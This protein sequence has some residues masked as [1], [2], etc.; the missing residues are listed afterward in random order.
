ME[1][2]K[3][4]QGIKDIQ[5]NIEFKNGF[6]KSK[7][8]NYSQV[9]KDK[10]L[11][12]K[13]MDDL[14]VAKYIGKYFEGVPMWDHPG[15]MINIT[16]PT[17]E[18][19]V[20]AATLAL[21]YN[22][23]LAYDKVSGSIC[24]AEFEVSKYICDL[25]GWNYKKAHGI[26]T[27]GGKAT[28]L[29]A[30]KCALLNACPEG[31]KKGY[32]P[33][34]YF[35]LTSD[36]CHVCHIEAMDWLG[37]GTENC[38]SIRTPAENNY[39]MDIK[40]AKEIIA[41]EIEKGRVFLGFNISGGST[42]ELAIDDIEKIYNIT[43]EIQKKYKLNYRPHIHIDSVLGWAGLFFNS[44]DFKNN[45]LNFS[46]ETLHA[47][48][49]WSIK[50]SKIKW[51]DSMG[52]DFHKTGY[53]PYASSLF[54]VK[55]RNKFLGLG[56]KKITEFEK[57]EHGKYAAFE[58]S[59]EMSRS[60]VGPLA[61]LAALKHL[62]VEG[63]QRKLGAL[64]D[65]AIY[66]KKKFAHSKEFLVLSANPYWIPVFV[67]IRPDWCKNLTV[68]GLEKLT[69]KQL[70][71]LKT[72]N[73]DFANWVKEM[74][75]EGKCPFI[76]TASSVYKVPGA[77]VGIGSLKIFPMSSHFDKEYVDIF[78]KQLTKALKEYKKAKRVL[79]K[80]ENEALDPVY[81]TL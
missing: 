50:I 30:T 57:L 77:N 65:A 28:N 80:E 64:L 18:M 20:A 34:K 8:F 25:V 70:E 9:I 74:N 10:T 41:T 35:M 19:A 45:P 16:L 27:F 1:L 26:F 53:C 56:P 76:F 15:T 43:V 3:V 39:E 12:I 6:T 24:L 13:P 23:N 14:N 22:P 46:E 36:I 63:F 11:N 42:H 68:E 29:Y 21:A 49:V 60:G 44:Y 47:I 54:L 33:G 52:I 2:R 4:I 40:Q 5:K 81:R 7:P 62:G 58:N 61:A 78:I 51:A 31:R 32:E 59:I 55:D 75:M 48:K 66:M 17:D 38:I 69:L 73:S 71:D 67:S 72:L 79:K 37:L